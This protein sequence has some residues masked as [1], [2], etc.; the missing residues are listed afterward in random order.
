MTELLSIEGVLQGVRLLQ[1]VQH[2]L[3]LFAAFWFILGAVDELAIDLVWLW[4][5]LTGWLRGKKPARFDSDVD[6]G[7]HLS[8]PIAV[9]V[10]AWQEAE[11]I[12]V[13]IGHT[14]RAWPQRQLHLYLG[15]YCND[16]A[17]VAAA[18]AGADGDPRLRLVVHD[19]PGPTTKADCLNRVYA[20]LCEDE[21]RAG[22]RF[23]GVILHDAEDMVHPDALAAIGRALRDFDFVQIPVRPEPQRTSPWVAGHYTDEFTEAHAKVLVVRDML[24]AALP[25]AGVGC[26]F[27]RPMLA[28][29]SAVRAGQDTPDC[30]AGPFAAE[31]LTEDYELGLLVSRAGGRSRFLRLRD[32]NGELIATRAF[33][34]GTLEEAVRQ[35]ARWIHGIALQGWERLGWSAHPVELWMAARDRRGPLIALVL[36]A[37][38]GLLVIEIVLGV[39]RLLGWLQPVPITPGLR[40][41]LEF[42][43]AALVWRATWRFGFTAHEYGLAE[44]GR[45]VLRIPVANLIAIFAGARAFRAYLRTLRG[46]AVRWDKTLHHDHPAAGLSRPEPAE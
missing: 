1:I 14:L 38:Y 42:S 32:R 37:A 29:L 35:K 44:G 25:A 17:T 18:I 28:R 19:R 6:G 43:F 21:A 5:R 12:G 27:A 15:C 8:G 7:R 11:V 9:L 30:K 16:P 22:L 34:P 10:P 26:G 31:C 20:A 39:A 36:T 41:M 40:H 46:E 4:S 13:M 3:L 2:E 24:G 33:F 45:A 23:A